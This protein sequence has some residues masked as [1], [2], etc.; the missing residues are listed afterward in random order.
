MAHL[1]PCFRES[2]A[3]N[4]LQ[5][6][7]RMTR[8]APSAAASSAPAI[9]RAQSSAARIRGLV[10]VSDDTPGITR[11]RRGKGFGYRL[12]NG[13]PIRDTAMIQRI[14]SLAIPPA[15]TNV[16]ICPNPNGH[17]QATGRDAEGASSI[18][19]TPMDGG[20]RRGQVLPHD[21][22]RRSA[23]AHPPP[24]QATSTRAGCPASKVLAAVMRL[25]E[26][27]LIRVGNEEYAKQNSRSA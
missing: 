25:L 16:W 2:P 9:S 12:P 5:P 7:T 15:W 24:V 23:A 3:A 10:A 14:N 11:I 21:G 20:P 22:L 4:F 17:M 18:A 13:R 1:F 6:V 19:T 26:K 8:G 27:T